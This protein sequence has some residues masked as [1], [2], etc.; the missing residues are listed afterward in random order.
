MFNATISSL[1]K[2]LAFKSVQENKVVCSSVEPLPFALEAE[3]YMGTWYEIQ[4]TSIFF[5][6]DSF[7]CTMAVYSDLDAEAGTFTS[8]NS[9]TVGSSSRR[10]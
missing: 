6:P 5:Q 9:S 7:D 8:Y 3:R 10:G 2:L 4:H 1:S